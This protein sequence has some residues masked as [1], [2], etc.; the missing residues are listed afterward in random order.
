MFAK[1]S[2]ALAANPDLLFTPL[3]YYVASIGRFIDNEFLDL[4]VALEA[5]ASKLIATTTDTESLAVRNKE[6]WLQWVDDHKSDIVAHAIAGA[7]QSLVDRMKSLWR[8]AT[9]NAV[10]DAFRLHDVNLL[11]V[12]KDA[13]GDRNVVAHTALMN[14]D[15]NYE[16]LRE[17]RRICVVRAMLVALISLCIGYRGQIRGWETPDRDD[18]D[19]ASPEWWPVSE[20]DERAATAWFIAAAGH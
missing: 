7:E 9:S 14:A 13:I 4:Q 11:R 6:A 3:A 1:L 20:E 8:K 2:R 15:G 16:C 17:M 12:H 5:F 18:P 19:P 10:R